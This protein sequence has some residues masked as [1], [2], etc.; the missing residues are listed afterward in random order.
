MLYISERIILD[1]VTFQENVKVVQVNDLKMNM[2]IPLH[3]KQ[4]ITMDKFNCI[5]ATVKNIQITG[6]VNTYH[7]EDIFT[8]TF[9]V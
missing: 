2:L 9:S 3:T 6:Y 7:L 8:N 4:L 1:N 5:N